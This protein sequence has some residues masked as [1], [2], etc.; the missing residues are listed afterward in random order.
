MSGGVDGKGGRGGGIDGLMNRDDVER[1]D[2]KMLKMN[3]VRRRGKGAQMS[4]RREGGGQKWHK[5]HIHCKY[6]EEGGGGRVQ[7]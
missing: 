5:G 4:T 3:E 7:R 2:E 6:E 1:W